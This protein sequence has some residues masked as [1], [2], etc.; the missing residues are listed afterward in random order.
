MSPS[1]ERWSSTA[2]TARGSSHT[3]TGA[4]N[5]DAHAVTAVA[6]PDGRISLYNDAYGASI[7]PDRHP[8]ALGRPGR[9]VWAEIWPLINRTDRKV[10]VFFPLGAAA[11]TSSGLN[12]SRSSGE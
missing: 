7:G 6:E 2:A 11:A 4:P 3:Q 12:P 5:Q 10:S 1:D 8:A 9:E